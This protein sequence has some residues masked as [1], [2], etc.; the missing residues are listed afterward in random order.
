[1]VH[2]W[3]F[4]IAFRLMAEEWVQ[5]HYSVFDL[6]ETPRVEETEPARSITMTQKSFYCE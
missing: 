2:E 3:L 4:Q 5:Y 1:M 6:D